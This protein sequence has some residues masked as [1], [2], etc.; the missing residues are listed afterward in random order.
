MINYGTGNNGSGN[1]YWQEINPGFV[2][3]NNSTT[4]FA[5]KDLA[6][7]CSDGSNNASW[8]I[9][10]QNPSFDITVNYPDGYTNVNINPGD[11]EV[12]AQDYP[13]NSIGSLLITKS[14]SKLRNDY[15]TDSDYGEIQV[16]AKQASLHAYTGSSGLES[17]I[18]V[19]SDLGIAMKKDGN[20][21]LG[22]NANSNI[23]VG[24][25]DAPATLTSLKKLIK[26]YDTTGALVGY[27]E[28]KG[29]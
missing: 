18:I 14:Y 12:G 22:I 1:S 3:I 26:I 10:P 19:N 2:Q 6:A 21:A 5:I 23:I 29:V 13:S 25:L 24:V 20:I 27:I 11:F 28:V 15:F 16:E 4:G 8:D 9:N 7:V 17:E